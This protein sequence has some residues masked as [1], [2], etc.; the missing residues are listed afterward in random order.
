MSM[1]HYDVAQAFANGATKGKGSRMN[2]DGDTVYSHG[3]WPIAKRYFKYDVDYLFNTRYGSVS[4]EHHR[5]YVR[6][7]ISGTVLVVEHCGIDNI[8]RQYKSNNKDIA[9]FEGKRDRARLHKDKW[10]ERIKEVQAQN[11]I[12][13]SIAVRRR[14]L[15]A[16]GQEL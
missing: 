5:S 8:D 15:K 12:L 1:S 3:H 4:T 11:D 10:E 6:N 9:E 7:A 13:R 2:I 16:A 14:L